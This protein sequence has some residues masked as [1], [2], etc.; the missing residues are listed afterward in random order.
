MPEA[1]FPLNDF[2]DWA[3]AWAGWLQQCALGKPLVLIGSYLFVSG[4]KKLPKTCSISRDPI[5]G[6]RWVLE[7]APK[8]P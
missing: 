1:S 7:I 3:S 8:P 4:S 6:G 5:R 2:K